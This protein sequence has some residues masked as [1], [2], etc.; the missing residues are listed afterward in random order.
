MDEANTRVRQLAFWGIPLALAV[1]CLKMLAWYLTGSVA[2]VDGLRSTVNVIEAVIAWM[3]VGYA[4][5]PADE[6][7]PFG[8]YKAEYVSAVIEGALIV[9]AALL[10]VQEA[11]AALVAPVAAERPRS[12]LPSMPERPSSTRSGPM[13]CSAPAAST[14]RRR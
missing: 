2:L 3:V 6:D 7:H 9:V 1:M 11:A 10:I 12:A 4:A 13:C 8:H 5:K 14:A